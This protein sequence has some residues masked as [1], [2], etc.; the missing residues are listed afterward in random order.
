[1]IIFVLCN[2][3]KLVN[4]WRENV[5]IASKVVTQARFIIVTLTIIWKWNKE[6][7][8]NSHTGRQIERDFDVVSFL[9]KKIILF[10][11][12]VMVML[13]IIMIKITTTTSAPQ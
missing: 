2:Q 3:N 1:M 5:Y 7:D 11:V 6:R 8:L 9:K 12:C 4:I 13:I 10:F